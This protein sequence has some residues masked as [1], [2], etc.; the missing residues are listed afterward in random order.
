MEGEFAGVH[1]VATY[2]A[3][4]VA[5]S[6]NLLGHAETFKYTFEKTGEYKYMCGPHP[7][8]KGVVIVTKS[9][10]SGA[11]SKWI[12]LLSIVSLI[13][14]LIVLYLIN[15]IKRKFKL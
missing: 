8:M 9:S 11:S 2:E 3:A 5:F 6:S 1:S 7:Y 4:P 10:S 13:L 14:L 12:I 15:S